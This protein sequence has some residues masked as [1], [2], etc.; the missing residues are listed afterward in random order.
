MGLIYGKVCIAAMFPQ[1]EQYQFRAECTVPNNTHTHRQSQPW[2][3]H[4][5]GSIAPN[6][7]WFF[8]FIFAIL[9]SDM[10]DDD[11]PTHERIHHHKD[12]RINVVCYS[13]QTHVYDAHSAYS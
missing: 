9:R 2:Y 5:L 13:S 4:S 12:I 1:C 7:F 6:S 11:G 8:F 3:I 10:K